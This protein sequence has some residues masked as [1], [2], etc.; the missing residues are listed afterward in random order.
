MAPLGMNCIRH[1]IVGEPVFQNAFVSRMKC[2][3]QKTV[4]RTDASVASD[5]SVKLNAA[6]EAGTGVSLMVLSPYEYIRL[7]FCFPL[8]FRA[9]CFNKLN[10]KQLQLYNVLPT[11]SHRVSPPAAI[12]ILLEVM[13]LTLVPGVY[14]F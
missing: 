8:L 4:Y 13:K 14:H 10:Y 1:C 9:L 12:C 5:H 7:V 3:K 6:P 2:E 11:P